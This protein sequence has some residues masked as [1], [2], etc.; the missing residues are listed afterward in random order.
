MAH[1]VKNPLTPIQLT[2]QRLIRRVAEGRLDPEVVQ[3]GAETILGEVRS[4]AK[5][6]DSFTRFAK[7]PAPVF[8]P[9][10]AGDLL[11]QVAAMYG[12]V[13]KDVAWAVLVPVEPSY[14]WLCSVVARKSPPALVRIIS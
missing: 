7:L 3:Q 13:R 11:R 2:A 1:E 14:M 4:L 6:V 9:C 12:P 5:L 8:G 10:D